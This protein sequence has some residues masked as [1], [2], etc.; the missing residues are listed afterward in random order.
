MLDRPPIAVV[1]LGA[2]LPGADSP[3]A[4]WRN[5]A[6][7]VDAIRD[8]PEGRWILDPADVLD[9]E[10]GPDKVFSTRG[11]YVD[12][13]RLDPSGL[14][15]DPG[16]LA[17]LDPLFHFVLHA[18]RQAFN[19]AVTE[20]L[21]RQRVGV[22]LAAIALP[23]DGS[24]ALTR[25]ILGSAFE[26][27]LLGKRARRDESTKG[28]RARAGKP[29]TALNAH[30]TALPAG[31]L[32]TALGLQGG[33]YTLDAACASSLCAIKLACDELAAGRAD[34]MLAGG[35][36]R[37]ECL[38][39]QMGFRLLQALSPSGVCRPFDAAADGLVVGEGAG[40]VLL[41]RLDDAVAAGDHVYGLI[42]GIGLSNDI[43]G[44]LL[45]ADGEGQLRAMRAAYEQAGWSPYDVDYIECHGTGTPLGDAV[46]LR[47][48]RTLW[49]DP[50][51]AV[52]A[53]GPSDPDGE[54][55]PG[56]VIGSVKSMIGHTLTAAGAA[57]VIKTLL[58]MQAQRLPPSLHF[59]RGAPGS[60]IRESPFRVQTE[61][62]RW[63][64]RGPGVPRRA[65][66]S[67]FGFGG[68]N[69]HVLIEE[70]AAADPR[71]PAVAGGGV[72]YHALPV[73]TRADAGGRNDSV[74]I[75][76][77]GLDARF[78]TVSSPRELAELVRH[79]GSA[80]R[81]RP[82]DRWRGADAL[83]L[84]RLDGRA[85]L[86]AYIDALDVPVGAFR[87]PPAEIPEILPQQL[88]MLQVAAAALADAS[89]AHRRPDPR[90]GVLIGIGLDL[91][92]SNYHQRW[93]L[94][95]EA[96]RWAREL[97]MELSPAE[98]ED[99][100]TQLRESFGPALTA[101]RVLGSLGSIVASR[102][103]REF[104]F[105]GPGF[106]VSAGAG[107]GLRALEIG[108]RALQRGELDRIVVGAV[109][110]AGD[111]R[112]VLV[113]HAVRSFAAQR[114][115]GAH[116]PSAHRAGV[117][118]G[119]VAVVLKRLPD[120]VRDGD[121]IYAVVRGLGSAGGAATVSSAVAARGAMRHS[122]E[123]SLRRAFEDGSIES[124]RT[125]F[126]D[127][128]TAWDASSLEASLGDSGAAAGLAALV[129][130]TLRLHYGVPALDRPNSSDR[131]RTVVGAIGIDGGCTHVLLESHGAPA[132]TPEGRR[133]VSESAR[134][135]D[136]ARA[137]VI[138]VPVGGPAPRPTLP[139]RYRARKEV[140]ASTSRPGVTPA[141]VHQ[142]AQH[143]SELAISLAATGAANAAAHSAY[144]QFA[145]VAAAGAEFAAK[146]Q[147][148]YLGRAVEASAAD[149]LACAVATATPRTNAV[150][151]TAGTR[152]GGRARVGGYALARTRGSDRST[153][154][155]GVGR[156]SRE[157][158]LEFAAGTV[159]AVLG[160]MFAPIDGYAKRVRLPDEPLMLVDRIVSVTGEPASL[161]HGTIATEHDVR[162]GAW[163]LDGGRTPVCIAV[164][165]GQA[166][167]FLCSYL[168]I[169]L[170]VKGTRAYR[171]LDA[172]IRFH[173][174]LPRPG[175]TVRYDIAIDKFVRQGDVWLFFFRFD[176]TIGGKPLLTMRNGCAGFFTEHEIAESG[177]IVRQPEDL[178]PQ[179]I[180][181]AACPW[182]SGIAPIGIETYDESRLDALRRGDLAACFG[183]PF[184][185]LDL[186][187]PLRIPGGRMRL[188]HR[189][190]ELDVRGGRWGL[191]LIRG[192]ADIHPDDWFL[193]CHF[194][195]DM[196][197]PGTLMYECCE[198]TLRVFLLRMGWCAA[199]CE[200]GFEPVLERSCT[201]KCRGPV[202]PQTKVVTYEVQIKEVGFSPEPYVIA[203]AFMYADGQRIVQFTGMSLRLAGVTR[204]DLEDVW[205]RCTVV[206]RT[207]PD[208]E[209]RM[210]NAERGTRTTPRGALQGA[211]GASV[212]PIGGAIPVLA[213]R[214][215]IFDRDRL[216]A[217]AVGN[218]S[219]AFGEPCT[220]FDRDRRMARLP[221]PPYLFL[222]RITEIHAE[223]WKLRPGGW[224]EAQYDVPPDAWYFGA[225]RQP[226][227]PY[228]VV[229][230]IALQSCGWLAAYLGSALGSEVDTRFRNLGGRATLHREVFPDAGTL[231]ARVRIT[232]VSAAAGMIIEKF[233][234]QLWQGPNRV[235][236]GDTY[237]G[238]FSDEA[239]AQQVGI[240][241]AA[242]RAYRPGIQ[243]SGFGEPRSA[244]SV[245][246]SALDHPSMPA[247][248]LRMV[249]EIDDYSR[250]G[251]P[252][253]RGF[254]RGVKHV[255]PDEWFFK[256]HFYQD[257]VCPGSLG[258][259]SFL[260]LLKCVAVDRFGDLLDHGHRFE[261]ILTREPH[262][263]VYRGQ[264]VPDHERVEVEAAITAMQAGENPCIRAD[265]FLKVD[266]VYIYEL[267][268]FGVRVVP[269]S[270]RTHCKPKRHKDTRSE[271]V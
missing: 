181:R 110:L 224:I 92:T 156:Y 167:L 123:V 95:S 129:V 202:T 136:A 206:E 30:V 264:I 187:D 72:G 48:L 260:Q 32:A 106:T 220:P 190:A 71:R 153:A 116:D 150:P 45:A 66:V 38:Y 139:K 102:I 174:E 149:P 244:L 204:A 159:A 270:S 226:S 191:G 56:C 50:P 125:A 235:Y 109:D 23:T 240:R 42:R 43:A 79:D 177:G 113:R 239:L 53:S 105:G 197:M 21:D 52:R 182:F 84:E 128:S 215:A 263:W 9:P 93:A 208:A 15:I 2:L 189:I 117:A 90:T 225:N 196:V 245:Q 271:H 137:R 39:T 17:V 242:E 29:I 25:E 41:K 231:T 87:I 35:V 131:Q 24:S 151:V 155:A 212:E 36:S 198:H 115:A 169:D 121:R 120:A 257:P 141:V 130:A 75:A 28:R 238:F 268:N 83:A 269:D 207:R 1:G 70:F 249:D 10:G 46:E 158:C 261:P 185:R 160:P 124:E 94:R 67:A 168:G 100:V 138:R 77:V 60:D 80:I 175:E 252:I 219:E 68:I 199:K 118:D 104:G 27:A 147:V 62:D 154:D 170:A 148:A 76:I 69:A 34:A 59:E 73:H 223:A 250:D 247:P 4:F 180:E 209:C 20:N 210:Q 133:V 31:L 178:S 254:I 237:F 47:S 194:V 82:A 54:V 243:G 140:A 96:R 221:G 119:A 11:G 122:H 162:E 22:I 166:D 188:L 14:N 142:A 101:G 192:E 236:E 7:K 251:G 61:L 19:D 40:I 135:S 214:P 229:L 203:D 184:D 57:G 266:G 143:V 111:V 6:A 172:Q 262:E 13:F 64:A 97:G 157:Q 222:D 265:G 18:G 91:N 152:H 248:A 227:M 107:S 8:V 205:D 127:R 256:A 213:P 234:M 163:Y 144:L 186:H 55:P 216:L 267:T 86:G 58:A 253:R 132:V 114:R 258:L 98:F 176:A 241:G 99:W 173:R 145:D 51:T 164:E 183:P 232:D 193:T 200:A 218:P 78:G 259:E 103:A 49:A 81:P 33:S 195:D 211:R 44:S 5:I 12:E 165:A 217:F 228:C 179:A 88:L 171:L 201:L 126:E 89:S 74:R 134:S 65:A 161:T 26:R 16:L 85:P 63:N 246:R 233:D 3:A 230:E 108:V 255:H 146:S 37:P 112:A